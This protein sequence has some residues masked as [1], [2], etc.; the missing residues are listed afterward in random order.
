MGPPPKKK[1]GPKP[2]PL[3]ERKPLRTTPIVRKE[4]SYSKQ[5]RKEVITWMVHHR[6][7]RLGEMV[8]PSAQDAENH[9]KIPRSTIAGWKTALYVLSTPVTAGN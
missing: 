9:F 1:R 5:K 4:N 7:S 6:V 8:P 3:S 2:K